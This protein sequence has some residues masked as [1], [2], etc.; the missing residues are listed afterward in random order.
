[1]VSTALHPLLLVPVTILLLTRDLRVSALIAAVTFLPLLAITLLNVRRGTWSNFDVSDREQRGGLYRAGVPLTLAG[2]AALYFGG[3][4]AGMV[5]GAVIASTMLLA[6]LLLS[7]F[8]KT[9]LHMLFA[10]WSGI[11]IIR[12]FP[13]TAPLVLIAVL[14]LAWSRLRLSRHTPPELLVGAV[15]G[16][17]GGLLG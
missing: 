1:M 4:S 14:A 2:A 8:L 16:V 3:A 6:G 12:T 9:S 11:L 7:P 17:A 10:S 5:R 13:L 15:I